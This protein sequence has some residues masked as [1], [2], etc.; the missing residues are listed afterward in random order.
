M[1][2]LAGL[3]IIPDDLYVER[4]ADTQLRKVIAEM[5]RPAYVLVARQMGKT[6]LLLHAKRNYKNAND[7][8]VYIDA[9]N[10]FETLQ[11]FFRSIIDATL[12]AGDFDANLGIQINA[13][14][15]TAGNIPAHR[16]HEKE[17]RRVLKSISGKLVIFLDEVD[18]L[19]G[20]QYSDQV[21]AYIRSIYF[22]A[23]T[24]FPEFNRLSYV[25]SG[26]AEPSDLIK[27]RDIS[28]FNIGQKI[29]LDD[30]SFS[31]FLELCR[32]SEIGISEQ[33]QKRVF[34]WTSGNPRMSWD[35]LAQLESVAD[36]SL[37][38]SSVDRIVQQLYLRSFDVPPVD[39]IRN[40]VAK[41]H[42]LQTALIALHYNKTDAV[43]A[44]AANKLYLAGICRQDDDPRN[45]SI[46]NKV[47]A[48]TLSLDWLREVESKQV[49]PIERAYLAY[50]DKRWAD[51]LVLLEEC[52]STETN[53][54]V[55]AQLSLDVAICRFRT[56][57]HDKTITWL[58]E[59]MP[60]KHLSAAQYYAANYWLG[61]AY[62]AMGDDQNGFK[63]F[64]AASEPSAEGVNIYFYECL[65]NSCAFYIKDWQANG[66]AIEEILQRIL[67]SEEKIK[68]FYSRDPQGADHVR[69]SAYW[70][71]ALL[72][73]RQGDLDSALSFLG[74]AIDIGDKKYLVG[75]ALERAKLQ[76]TSFLRWQTASSLAKLIIE[77]GLVIEQD[78]ALFPLAFTAHNAAELLGILAARPSD[79]VFYEFI[80]YLG[81][82]VKDTKEN[83][84]QVTS[85]AGQLA[86]S[87]GVMQG[88]ARL[89][90]LAYLNTDV[91]SDHTARMLATNA[92]LLT[93][94]AEV[95]QLEAKY[96]SDYIDGADGELLSSDFRIAYGL[97]Q[98]HLYSNPHRAREVVRLVA[99][100]APSL[101]AGN[102]D[103]K[104]DSSMLI[105]KLI[106]DACEIEWEYIHGQ[107]SVTDAGLAWLQASKA[108]IQASP[109]PYFAADFFSSLVQRMKSITFS[110]RAVKQVKR[111]YRKFGRNELV[112]VIRR[113]GVVERGKFKHLE[114]F[115][116]SG[117]YRLLTEK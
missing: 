107:A 86:L 99:Q 40:L 13:E 7:V 112:E 12:E 26:V 64:S 92:M 24:N 38:E 16:S 56:Q 110:K 39:H 10:P 44:H 103:P 2:K 82:L 52:H 90:A 33:I 95:D 35:V 49:R 36:A 30:F 81:E 59:H 46:R 73:K 104:S 80:D 116:K 53:D 43:T 68:D 14:R 85:E 111:E 67:D 109:P 1:S 65:V 57:A 88:A 9:S 91:A 23:R 54:G 48:E 41:D 18:A 83:L 69:S 87:S 97:F 8:F 6:N 27:N 60:K 62:H 19:G 93:P 21:F 108:L 102:L 101:I 17:L 113:D 15:S 66:A 105:G 4:A 70:H 22:A 37:D 45:L 50:S 32:K 100:L 71:Y 55:R 63:C 114:Q 25:L 11:E 72:R 117:E 74:K 31:E 89:F 5:G 115:I 98:G 78:S 47:I 28:P 94:F 75:M 51:A 76:S 96:F 106:L 84:A 42:E 77:Q 79:E 29:Y 3:T 58:N 34:D 20:R 61:M